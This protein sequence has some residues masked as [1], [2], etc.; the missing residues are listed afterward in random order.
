[1]AITGPDDFLICRISY[2]ACGTQYKMKIKGFYS[3]NLVGL[4][5]HRVLCPCTDHA[6]EDGLANLTLVLSGMLCSPYYHPTP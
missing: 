1:M 4:S 2:V 5:E 3:K 6:H